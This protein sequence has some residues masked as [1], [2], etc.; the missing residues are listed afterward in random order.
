M[1]I[2]G[3]KLRL[4]IIR[5]RRVFDMKEIERE[6]TRIVFDVFFIFGN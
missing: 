5:L 3:A 2:A 6:L 1:S 4:R